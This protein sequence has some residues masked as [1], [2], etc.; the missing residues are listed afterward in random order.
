MVSGRIVVET[1]YTLPFLSKIAFSQLK[2]YRIAIRR[3]KF[4]IFQS[5]QWTN[6]IP[7]EEFK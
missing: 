5:C 6:R 1:I 7:I 4:S 3:Y 2:P